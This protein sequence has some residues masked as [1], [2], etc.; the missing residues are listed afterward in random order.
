[1]KLRSA[2]LFA[3]GLIAITAPAALASGTFNRTGSMNVARQGHTGTLLSNGQVLVAGG[4][5]GL[6]GYLSS[7][8]LYNSSTGTWALTGSMSVPRQ[9][10]QSRAVAEWSSARCWRR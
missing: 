5:D 2:G 3:I 9:N 7:T 8:E 1:M 6:I 10:H 4:A